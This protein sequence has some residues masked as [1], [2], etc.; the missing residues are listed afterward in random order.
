MEQA[1]SLLATQPAMLKTVTIGLLGM[2]V[3]MLVLKPVAGQ[4]VATMKQPLLLTGGLAQDTL[5]S[6]DESRGLRGGLRRANLEGGAETR[7]RQVHWAT[8]RR[9]RPPTPLSVDDAPRIFE[10][11]SSHIKRDPVHSTRLL[12]AWIA[13]D[14]DD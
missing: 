3:V 12:E 2:M 10:E 8:A 7:R 13:Q 1:K 14:G 11:V 5:D 4:V 6:V 9:Y